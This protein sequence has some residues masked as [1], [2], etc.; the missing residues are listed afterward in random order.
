MRARPINRKRI[1]RLHIRGQKWRIVIARPPENKCT[2]LCDY[3]TRTIFIRPSY[4]AKLNG[5]I[6]E[7]LHACFPDLTEEAVIEAEHAMA[8]AITL[9]AQLEKKPLRAEY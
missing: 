6:H 8:V 2:A 9:A 1:R 5:V 4:Q 3:R 7:V